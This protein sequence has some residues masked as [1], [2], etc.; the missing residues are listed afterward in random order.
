MCLFSRLLVVA[1]AYGRL[2][3]ARGHPADRLTGFT[4]RQRPSRATTN[5]QIR[6]IMHPI[7]HPSNYTSVHSPTH[8]FTHLIHSPTIQ[9]LTVSINPPHP[10]TSPS[11]HQTIHPMTHTATHPHTTYHSPNQSIHPYIHP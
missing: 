2:I 11:N 7:T 5:T 3:H 10:F 9:S 1:W 6:P 4:P 8:P